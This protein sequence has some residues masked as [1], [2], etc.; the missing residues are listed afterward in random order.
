MFVGVFVGVFVG[1]GC[2]LPYYTS[3]GVAVYSRSVGVYRC[4]RRRR[5]WRRCG[6]CT[7]CTRGGAAEEGLGQ[8]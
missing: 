4:G 7:G 1:G 5:T 3:R 2:F 6:C 8:P